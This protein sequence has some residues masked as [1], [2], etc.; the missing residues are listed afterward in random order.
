MALYPVILQL[1]PLPQT[2][3]TL[4]LSVD[5][6]HVAQAAFKAA[7]LEKYAFVWVGGELASRGL[8]ILGQSLA[9]EA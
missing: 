6:G 2:C 9:A 5:R 8:K 7:H 3:A 1:K 4:C